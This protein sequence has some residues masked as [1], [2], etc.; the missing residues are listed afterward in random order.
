MGGWNLGSTSSETSGWQWWNG[1]AQLAQG[2]FQVSATTR[3]YW[4]KARSAG[5]K[6]LRFALYTDASQNPTEKPTIYNVML[7]IGSALADYSP[8]PEE[9]DYLREALTEAAGA[10][11]EVTGGLILSRAMS[12]KDASGVMVAG[13]NGTDS[14]KAGR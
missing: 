13:L 12:V 7:S 5:Y 2:F 4:F 6:L 11:T 1:G 14:A 3:R 9:T 8:A 10:S